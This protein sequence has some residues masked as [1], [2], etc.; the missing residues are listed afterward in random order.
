MPKIDNKLVI[1]EKMN[2]LIIYSKNLLNKYPKSERFD[3]CAD[4]KHEEYMVLKQIICAWK[5]KDIKEKMQVLNKI[6]I[7]LIFLKSLVKISYVNKYITQKNF[8]VWSEKISELG[9]MI[10]GWI[11]TCQKD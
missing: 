7:E 8:L 10:G 4:I 9:K 6:D 3:L 2:E 11:K 5:M 1:Y